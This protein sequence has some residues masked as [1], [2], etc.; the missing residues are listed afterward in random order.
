MIKPWP[1]L[2][3]ITTL[4]LILNF[5]PSW[6]LNLEDY[7]PHTEIPFKGKVQ[8]I[9]LPE[10]GMVSLIILK[11]ERAYQV[12]LCPKWFYLQLKP[13]L[14]IGDPVEVVGTKIY[15]KKRGVLFSAKKIKNLSTQEEFI[16]RDL[17]CHPCWKGKTFKK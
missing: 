4:L 15:S 5:K 10:R 11:E 13:N 2:F 17:H 8:E 1:F 9:L 7:N 6:A 14:K 16:F 12:F 3:Y